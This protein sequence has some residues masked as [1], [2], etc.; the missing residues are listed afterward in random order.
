MLQIID[1]YVSCFNFIV[2]LAENQ[3]N[4]E[5]LDAVLYMFEVTKDYFANSETSNEICFQQNEYAV[6]K[7]N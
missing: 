2:E 1:N 7:N 4:K 5:L 6:N 3:E